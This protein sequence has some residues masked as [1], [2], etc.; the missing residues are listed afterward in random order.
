[1]IPT[2]GSYIDTIEEECD[3]PIHPPQQR[4]ASNGLLCAEDR[5]E[6]ERVLTACKTK[7]QVYRAHTD[8]EYK[9]G[10]EH[11]ALIKLIEDAYTRFCT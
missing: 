9:G 3:A 11:R 1:M 4:V 2:D 8:G 10:M 6:L 7:L 5:E